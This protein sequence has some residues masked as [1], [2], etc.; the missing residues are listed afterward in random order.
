MI[1]KTDAK[2]ELIMIKKAKAATKKTKTTYERFM[3][4]LSPKEKKEFDESYR[5]LLLSE[6][7]LAIMEQDEVSVRELAKMAKVSPTIVQA[8][9]SGTRKNYSLETF[10]KI[11]KS[12]GFNQFMVG[13][14]GHFT[15]I[16]FSHLSKK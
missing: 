13:R 16:D 7:L 14:N 2:R 11:L 12:L 5:E 10:Y 6:L 1:I 15:P 8:M 4:K 9:R 3:E